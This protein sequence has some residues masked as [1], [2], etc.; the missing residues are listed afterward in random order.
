MRSLNPRRVL[1]VAPVYR[2]FRRLIA[3]TRRDAVVIDLLEVEAGHR[4]LD[5]GCGTGDILDHLPAGMAYVGLDANRRYIKTAM[6]RHGQHGTFHCYELGGGH[7]PPLGTFDRVLAD[8]V[9]HHL[10]SKTASALL[11]LAADVLRPGGHLVTIDPCIVDEQ[12]WL[13][14]RLIS[15]DRGEHV[16]TAPAYAEL[17]RGAFTDVRS[18]HYEN[19]LRLPYD[20]VLMKCASPILSSA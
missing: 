5:I 16:R 9:I 6:E 20:H 1:S 4:L 3:G 7:P 10:H 19:L 18:T 8:G 15:A 2:Q 11:A 13:A 14:R 12:H 17:A